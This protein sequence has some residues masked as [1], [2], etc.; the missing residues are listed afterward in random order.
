MNKK[1]L[2][3]AVA[4]VV[5]G[6]GAAFAMTRPDKKANDSQ[7]AQQTSAEAD[8][9]DNMAF[10]P[11]ATGDSS[12]VAI[13]DTT[14]DG[15]TTSGRMEYDKDN[16]ALRFTSTSGEETSVLVYTQDA[17]YFCQTED[18]CYKAALSQSSN[19]SFDRRL[20]EYSAEEIAA[21]RNTA[22]YQGKQACPSGSCDTWKVSQDGYETTLY[23]DAGSKRITQVDGASASGTTKIVYE[24]KDVTVTPPANAQD[25]PSLQGIGN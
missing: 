19:S 17:Y 9:I 22:A 24:Y 12:F 20:Y 16:D 2:I 3:A 18:T 15:Q 25:L 10:D 14:T 23:I 7:A 6:G 8:S 21:F 4:L 11:L 1:V 13:I 5:V